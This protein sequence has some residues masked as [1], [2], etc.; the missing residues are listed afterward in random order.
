MA[1]SS[2]TASFV[3]PVIGSLFLLGGLL[4]V[5]A[6]GTTDSARTASS[7]TVRLTAYDSTSGAPLD[8]AHAVNRTFGDTMHTDSAGQ[9]VMRDVEPA[10]YVFDIGG[11]GYHPQRHVSVLVEP[12]DTTITTNVPLLPM[13]LRINCEGN[14]PYTWDGLVSKYREDSSRVRIQL[15]DVFARDG[16]VQVQPVVVNDLPTITVFVPDNLGA[17]GHY[18]VRLY[19]ENGDPIAYHHE[20]APPDEGHRIYSKGD[21]L[22]VVP[23]DAQRLEPSRLIV[24]DSIADGATVYARLEYTF[25][26]ENTLQATSATTFPDLNL[27][28]LQVPVFDTLRTAGAVQVPDSLMLRRDT[29][30]VRVA[31]ID[32]TVSRNG[33]LL[34]STLR[35]SNAASSP[36]AARQLLYVP[37]SVEAR[38]RRDSL[39]A[40]AAADSTVPPIDTSTVPG[41]SPF[42]VVDRTDAARLRSLITDD[43]LAAS[44]STGL[45]AADMTADTLLSM[46]ATLRDAF[47]QPPTLSRT[48]ARRGLDVAPDSTFRDSLLLSAPASDSL[49]RMIAPDSA[50]ATDATAPPNPFTDVGRLNLLSPAADSLPLDSLRLTV[51]P[52][53]D[54]VV[55]TSVIAE[56]L[57]DPPART[58]WSVPDSLSRG[59]TGVMVVDPSFF[60]LRAR[61]HVDTTARVNIAGLLPDRVG[62]RNQVLA[63]RYPQQVIRA[64]AGTYRRRYLQTW[65]DVQA[66]NLKGHYCQILPF[67]LRSEWQSTSMRY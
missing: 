23:Q 25:S 13:Q 64:P 1:S 39:E 40:A 15:L 60:R 34:F 61:P 50:A 8:S 35:E 54:S 62:P 6:C 12:E 42:L 38:A 31:G 7:R 32:T 21:V 10:L 29:T 22:P 55:E 45:P 49:F 52:A 18:E 43:R 67:P 24:E 51:S 37:D 27:D 57:R 44:L 36:E 11:Y 65:R 2:A 59:K 56:D 9:F 19:N 63:Q 17:L 14:R 28:S 5:S 30:V 66:A 46:S 58:V 20:D 16:E 48:R 53:A 33:Y 41:A 47:L 4:L 3:R 26:T